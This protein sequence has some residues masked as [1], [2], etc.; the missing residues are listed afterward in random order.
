MNPRDKLHFSPPHTIQPSQCFPVDGEPSGSLRMREFE[1]FSSV[2]DVKVEP[3]DEGGHLSGSKGFGSSMDIDTLSGL[4][5]STGGLCGE[6]FIGVTFSASRPWTSASQ[7]HEAGGEPSEEGPPAVVSSSS[8]SLSPQVSPEVE[9]GDSSSAVP[10]PLEALQGVPIPP[11]LSKTYDLVDDLVLD[12]IIAWGTRGASFVVWDPVEFARTILPQHFKH[13][14]FSSFIRQLNTYGFR[15][16]KTDRWE[17]ANEDFLRG[18]RNLLKKIRRR[19]LPQVQHVGLHIEPY[20]EAV[21]VGSDMEKLR[22]ERSSLM[23]EVI[24]LQQEHQQTVHEVDTMTKRLERAEQRQKQMVSFLAK[25]LQNTVFMSHFQA[26]KNRTNIASRVRRK[27]LKQQQAMQSTSG[28]SMA[29]GHIVR[30]KTSWSGSIGSMGEMQ[31]TGTETGE[32]VSGYLSQDFL[33]RL[34]ETQGQMGDV[35]SEV[36]TYLG[37]AMGQIEADSP[38]SVDPGSSSGKEYLVSFPEELS[39]MKM[40]PPVFS[41]AA[42]DLLKPEE[43]WEM[44]FNIGSSNAGSSQDVWDNPFGYEVQESLWSLG[45][46]QVDEGLAID[47]W[48]GEEP[49][50]GEAET[51]LYELP[52]E[53]RSKH[54]EP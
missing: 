52:Y 20:T 2:A 18:Q 40:L 42:E 37:E 11:F 17:F 26:Q 43:A 48:M 38:S 4:Q 6:S 24:K 29:E 16:I 3:L 35:A 22:K 13:N 10:Q 25:V 8:S 15:K 7:A 30:Y 46:Q 39:P 19:K 54:N 50:L 51:T 23:Q 32:Q 31:E 36:M 28:P 14:N 27:F 21:K 47:K 9:T 12:S 44:G 1:A 34:L 33:G 45:C 49:S 41:P 5:S 53:D